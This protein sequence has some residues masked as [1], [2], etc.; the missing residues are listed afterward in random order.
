[1]QNH[2][3]AMWQRRHERRGWV[4]AAIAAIPAITSTAGAITGGNAQD[5]ARFATAQQAYRDALNGDADSACQLKHLTGRYGCTTCGRFGQ[6][7]GFATAAAKAYCGT[8][9][10]QYVQQKSGVLSPNAPIPLPAGGQTTPV[11]VTATTGAG[12][13]G[14]GVT[15]QGPGTTVQLGTSPPPTVA[16]QKATV[17]NWVLVG[18]AAAAGLALYFFARRRG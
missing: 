9:Y 12:G 16:Q 10:D 2:P 11:T 7:C 6:T 3:S 14:G 1:M 17:I 13:S 15:F 8:L 18:V 5:Q 4:T